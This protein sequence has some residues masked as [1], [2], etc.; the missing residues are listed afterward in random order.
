MLRTFQ[1]S[2]WL[3]ERRPAPRHARVAL[4]ALAV[5]AALH[6]LAWL[7]LPPLNFGEPAAE[8]PEREKPVR[9]VSVAAEPPPTPP[10]RPTFTPDRPD[11][12]FAA[13]VAPAQTSSRMDPVLLQAPRPTD[14]A[15]AF[16]PVREP[17][18]PP[19]RENWQPRAERV[20]IDRQVAVRE[21]ASLPRRIEPDVERARLTPD[22]IPETEPLAPPAPGPDASAAP[23]PG[24]ELFIRRMGE[25]AAA[26]TGPAVGERA[27]TGPVDPVRMIEEGLRPQG[28]RRGEITDVRPIEQMLTLAVS[29]Y[30]DPR[31]PEWMYF[32]VMIA[33]AGEQ[34]LPVLPKDVL[35]VQDCSESMTTAKVA[36][37]KQGIHALLKTL[38]D[39]DRL[40]VI[41]FRET[42]YR[43][44][45]RWMPATIAYRAQAGWF[46]EQM[47]SRGR[48]D[49]YASL[50]RIREMD[51]DPARPMI[52]LILT[53][54]RPTAG[55]LDTFAIIDDFT[56]ENAGQ[57]SVFAFGG[58]NRVNRFLLDF[59]SFKN[60]GDSRVVIRNDEIPEAVRQLGLEISRPVLHQLAYRLA[61]LPGGEVYPRTLTSLY[62]DRPLVLY[63]R[64]PAN[65]SSGAI[66]IAGQA[67]PLR[68]DMVFRLDWA[69]AA[70][71]DVS[72]RQQW[73]RQKIND[74]FGDYIHSQDR[75]ALAE[76]RRLSAQTGPDLPYSEYLILRP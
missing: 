59:L 7:E 50:T 19:P 36:Q 34:A 70:A 42:T 37:C 73:V 28:A 58:G 69:R 14:L 74:L 67:G 11:E 75:S 44:F 40:E 66:Q 57:T 4:A 47:E 55:Q 56:R 8:L 49:V 54:G 48:T 25:R 35:I 5:S 76:I 21:L 12:S 26:V 6:V 30:R 51:R 41:G 62:L 32:S 1:E 23:L 39:Q 15:G 64:A 13:P 65:A 10:T 43:C 17:S 20:E 2:D 60:R 3:W 24:D 9:V 31:E 61:N 33:R 22:I 45:N 71:G 16:R 52:A 27:V 68:H 72:I 38:S 46:V 63:G 53:D 29:T 18:P